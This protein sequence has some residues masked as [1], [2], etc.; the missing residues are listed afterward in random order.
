MGELE[1]KIAQM[2]ADLAKLKANAAPEPYD[3]AA[4]LRWKDEQHANAERR[5]SRH[6]PFSRDQLASMNAACSA[7]DIQDI[8]RHGTVQSPSQAGATGQLTKVSSN[9]GIIGS[10]T[11]GW[12][13]AIPL[14]PPPGIRYIDQQMA[15]EDREFRRQ[16]AIEDGQRRAFLKA[17]KAEE[18]KPK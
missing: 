13:D 1:N 6:N 10:N 5:A 17:V 2:E 8:V 18:E 4:M 12:R 3:A 9:A 11:T 7:S 16:R 15:A 14:S